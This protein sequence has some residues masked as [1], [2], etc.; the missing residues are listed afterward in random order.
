M[1]NQTPVGLAVKPFMESGRLVP[2]AV[3]IDVV[4]EAVEA[5][6][7]TNPG[8]YVLDGFPRTFR[9]AEA[10]EKVLKKRREKID[11]VILI[12]TPDEVIQGRLAQRRSCPDPLCGA[13]Y[14]VKSKPPK[15][16]NTCDLCGKQLII[17][18]D[19]R[20]ETIRV[21]QLQYWHDTAP[22][23]DFYERRGMLTHVPGSGSLEEV[24]ALILQ[25]ARSVEAGG[26][27]KK[28]LHHNKRFGAKVRCSKRFARRSGP[29]VEP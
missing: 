16:E 20:P 19:D 2:D 24:S 8:G 28:S 14:N 25:A 15:V 13:V 4:M 9:Q 7:K 21:R 26:K 18:E 5:A 3:V 1:A 12:D 17:R 23:V 22:L 11:L 6:K 27:K 10:L 29:N